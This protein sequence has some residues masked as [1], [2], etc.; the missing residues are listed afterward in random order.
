MSNRKLFDFMLDRVKQVSAERSL[1]LPQAFARWFVDLYFA[2]PQDVLVSD[3][4]WDGKVDLSCSFRDGGARHQLLL[5]S[6][7]TES[8][9]KR[10]PPQFYRGNPRV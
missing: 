6:K 3:G 10:A 8:F 7:F 2:S 1:A 9:E 4:A 5:N